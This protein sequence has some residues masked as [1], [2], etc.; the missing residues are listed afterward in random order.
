MCF[1]HLCVLKITKIPFLAVRNIETVAQF[2][3]ISILETIDIA[4]L[5]LY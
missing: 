5:T 1:L 4:D 2:S 3:V